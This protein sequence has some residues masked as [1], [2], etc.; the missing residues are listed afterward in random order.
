MISLGSSKLTV[1][2]NN[3]SA[4]FSGLIQDGGL[5]GGTGGSLAKVG[6]RTFTL[7]GGNLYTGG[8]TVTLGDFIVSNKTGSATGPG[9]VQVNG[10]RIG[11]AGTI[12][13]PLT[14][15]DPSGSA[16]TLIPALGSK[17]QVVLNVS[18]AVTFNAGASYS[19][20]LNTSQSTSDR[21]VANGVTINAGASFSFHARGNGV[22]PAGTVFTAIDNTAATPIAG[23]FSNLAEGATIVAGS[24]TYQVSY[25]GGTGNDITL[26]VL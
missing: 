9:P 1:G 17:K 23:N 3:L 16:A 7:G 22:L 12:A 5:S 11:G 13:G 8:T 20:S 4:T 18:S 10:G 21:V 19:Y 25:L 6:T 24:N 15:G 14:I 2:T 26:T